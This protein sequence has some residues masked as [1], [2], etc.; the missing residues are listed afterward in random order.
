MVIYTVKSQPTYETIAI[1][2]I[3]IRFRQNQDIATR[4]EKIFPFVKEVAKDIDLPC[5]I[6]ED[7]I[8][9]A[10]KYGFVELPTVMN[11]H[12]V[13]NKSCTK[14]EIKVVTFKPTL[15]RKQ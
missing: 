12:L 6:T 10:A 9:A 8:I 4:V 1:I 3:D 7:H 5:D 14:V 15:I 2:N 13:V 11:Y